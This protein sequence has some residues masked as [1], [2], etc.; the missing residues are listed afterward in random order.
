M[1]VKKKYIYLNTK[2][3][4]W[5]INDMSDS[6]KHICKCRIQWTLGNDLICILRGFEC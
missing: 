3:L 2:G 5:Y 1:E 4:N 6:Q